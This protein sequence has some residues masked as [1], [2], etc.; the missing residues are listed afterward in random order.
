MGM[1]IACGWV[2]QIHG[3]AVEIP[4]RR[5]RLGQ[6]KN[7]SRGWMTRLLWVV[8][9]DIFWA[10]AFDASRAPFNWMFYSADS[11][12]LPKPAAGDPVGIILPKIRNMSLPD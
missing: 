12:V 6:I 11:Q 10:P 7:T 5:N 4:S 9:L 2:S 8:V 3:L 1:A